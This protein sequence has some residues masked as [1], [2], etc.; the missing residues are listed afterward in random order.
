[1]QP[2]FCA[3]RPDAQQGL[4]RAFHLRVQ[5]HQAKRIGASVGDRDQPPCEKVRVLVE[6][7]LLLRV[8]GGIHHQLHGRSA[9]CQAEHEEWNSGKQVHGL[10]TAAGTNADTSALL[11]ISSRM[12]VLL[13][14]ACSGKAGR[15][16]VSTPRRAWFISAMLRSWP[17]SVLLRSPRTMCR[18]PSRTHRS[19]VRPSKEMA[20]T[21][22]VPAKVALSQASRCSKGNR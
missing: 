1:A 10:R 8:R 2:Q 21:F 9:Q 19:A 13:I 4:L 18:A 17:W 7:H 12:M 11:A 5:E 6:G 20:S 22:G 16:M 3:H 15:K 14:W